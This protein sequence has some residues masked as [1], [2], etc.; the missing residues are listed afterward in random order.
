[1]PNQNLADLL[2]NPD[3]WKPIIGLFS[4]TLTNFSFIIPIR[5]S[6]QLKHY[7]V[8]CSL[9]LILITSFIYHLCDNIRNYR[10]IIKQ[11]QSI[12]KD[13]VRNTYYH[14]KTSSSKDNRIKY[15]L[16]LTQ[17][18]VVDQSKFW[19]YC[20]VR[21]SILL[22]L[23][24]YIATMAI[25][26]M[27]FIFTKIQ[28][29]LKN[30][31]L[32]VSSWIMIIA[33]L[34]NKMGATIWIISG[35]IGFCNILLSRFYLERK[36]S[37]LNSTCQTLT[38]SKGTITSPSLNQNVYQMNSSAN[39]SPRNLSPVNNSRLHSSIDISKSI[40]RTKQNI[41]NKPMFICTKDSIKFLV[42]S[43]LLLILSFTIKGLI[44]NEENYDLRFY[45]EN[46][47]S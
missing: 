22:F 21:H 27:S 18:H 30:N 8:A 41:G 13:F 12:Q 4:V 44:Q 37:I 40:S 24:F 42:I 36:I 17:A 46:F 20:P 9:L 43:V 39:T 25:I 14:L 32:M 35:S 23:D 31:L 19:Y 26:Y 6:I 38:S 2:E 45:S 1:M 34:L 47:C 10:E 16:M 28:G 29:Q 5:K 15:E 33:T 7:D 11:T 3:P